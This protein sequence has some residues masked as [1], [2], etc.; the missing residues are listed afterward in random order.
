MCFYVLAVLLLLSMPG[1]LPHGCIIAI[2]QQMQM[3]LSILNVEATTNHIPVA[4][5]IN[6][7]YMPTLKMK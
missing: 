7:D 4:M 1:T 2:V 6:V 5:S 3:S